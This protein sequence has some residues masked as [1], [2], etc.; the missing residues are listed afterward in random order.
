VSAR[1]VKAAEQ[2]IAARREQ[3]GLPRAIHVSSFVH[4]EDGGGATIITTTVVVRTR[5]G[6]DYELWE[7]CIGGENGPDGGV[8]ACVLDGYG[9]GRLGG[10][11]DF[12]DFDDEQVRAGSAS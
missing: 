5:G 8:F 2:R 12:I 11:L 3:Q 7:T 9:V 10:D 6:C 4:D 1:D